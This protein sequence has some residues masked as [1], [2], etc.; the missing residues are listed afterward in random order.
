MAASY[1]A[2]VQHD[3]S[4]SGSGQAADQ[5]NGNQDRQSWYS[6][7]Q[8]QGAGNSWD[9]Y[10]SNGW[11][12]SAP[13]A[14]AWQSAPSW[15]NAQWG[16]S[17]WHGAAWT[18]DSTSQSKN[19]AAESQA[20]ASPEEA[21]TTRRQSA[22]TME[23][24]PWG[25][26]EGTGSLDDDQGSSSKQGSAAQPKAT[27]KDYIPEY[28]GTTPMREYQR[29]VKLFEMSTGIDPSFRAQKLM[30]K[31]SGNAWLA[32]ESIPLELEPL[33]FLRTFQTLAD[34][35]KGFRRSKGQ[36]FVA[37]DMEFR[38]HGQRLEE[39][40]AG[41][42]G[43]TKAY[44]FLEKASLS[45][46][47]RKQVV[48]AA[49]GQYDYNKLRAAVMAI[50][51]QVNKE[52]DGPSTS[53]SGGNHRQWRRSPAKVHATTQDGDENM[54]APEGEEVEEL[55][56]E[57]LEE[58]LQVLMTQ[59]AKK[60]AQVERARGYGAPPQKGANRGETPE[61]RERRI[62]ELKRR[63]PCS[64]CK[65]NGRTVYGHWHSDAS[66]PFNQKGKAEA[67]AGNVMAVIE[68]ELSDS[69]EYGPDSS[70]VFFTEYLCASAVSQIEVDG[71]DH[72]LAL[73]DTCCAR[74]VAGE[75]WA[76]RHMRHL[77]G[78]GVDV[79]VVDEQ[80]P[81]RF[82]AGP[83]V[84]SRYGI[85][86]PLI[87]EAAQV[88]P[89]VR[90]SV[91]QQDV[92][93]LLSKTA[94]KGLGARLD[95]GDSRILLGKLGTQA[96]LIETASGLCGFMINDNVAFS[97]NDMT[98]PPQAMLEGETEIY[99]PGE[100]EDENVEPIYKVHAE[101]DR[102]STCQKC[103]TCARALIESR[104]FSYNALEMLANLLPEVKMKKQ[105]AINQAGES[106]AQG[107]VAGVWAHGGFSG[108]TRATRDLPWTI[109]YINQFLRQQVKMEWSSFVLMKNIKT[110]LHRDKNNAKQALSATV[111]FGN[112]QGG[113]LWMREG[114]AENQPGAS[115]DRR[116]REGKLVKGT[117]VSTREKPL[118]FD[119]RVSHGTQRW[120]GTRWCLTC[121]TS[122]AIVELGDNDRRLLHDLKFP[123]KAVDKTRTFGKV[124]F[125]RRVIQLDQQT[126]SHSVTV[127]AMVSKYTAPKK[128]EEYVACIMARTTVSAEELRKHDVER[129]K[130]IWTLIKPKKAAAPLPTGW[131]KYDV[132]ALKHLYETVVVPDLQRPL[133]N[134]WVR[135]QR[136][137]LVTEID[138]WAQ[139]VTEA[140]KDE[141]E[142]LYS[143]TPMC[144]SCQ[145]PFVIRTNR[146]TREDFFG[147]VRFP[148][149]R[150]T[151]ALT[152]NGMPA[153]TVQDGLEKERK[154]KTLEE[155]AEDVKREEKP[156]KFTGYPKGPTN[157]ARRKTPCLTEWRGDSSDGSWART[158]PL[159]VE[160]DSDHEDSSK[161]IN[162]NLTSEEMEMIKQLR[163]SKGEIEKIRDGC[164]RRRHLKKGAIK[165]FLGN[166]KA[167][168]ASVMIASTAALGMA[169]QSVPS[170]AVVRPDVLEVF[171]GEAQVSSSFGRW[172][173]STAK[174]VDLKLGD[175]KCDA[176]RHDGLLEW[177]ERNRPRLVVVSCAR[178]FK[179]LDVIDKSK[180]SQEKRRL[181]HHREKQ[182][183]FVHFV[184]SVFER[185][186]KRGDDVL[187]STCA[188]S[189]AFREPVFQKIMNHPQ[190]YATA[191]DSRGNSAKDASSRFSGSHTVLWLS[192]AL[193]I[194]EELNMLSREGSRGGGL[195]EMIHSHGRQCASAICK[196]YVK[197]LKRKDPSRV[198]KMLRQVA[199]RIRNPR[200]RQVIRDLRWNEKNISKALAR[201]SAVFAVDSSGGGDAHS[202]A[203]MHDPLEDETDQELLAADR[204]DQGGEPLRSDLAYDGVKFEVPSGRRLSPEIKEG[205]RKAH[206][207]LGHPSKA[208]L[209]RFLKLGG[210]KQEVV[211]AVDWMQCVSCAHSNRPKAHR[212]TNIPPCSI[213]FGDE[214]HLDCFCI[215][216]NT[217]EAYWFL[218]I[219]DR[220]TSY[221]VVELLR[222]HSPNELHRAFD[223]AWA[224]WAGPPLRVSVDFEGGFRGKEF[225]NQVSESGASLVSI[226]GTAHWQ[227][228][229]VERHNQT[230]KDM[231]RT[232]IRHTHVRGREQIRV[233]G[234]E[235]CWAKNT[236]VREH[237][238]S[239]VALVF[240]KEP[241]VFGE[242][243][244]Q[245]EPNMFH[246][247]V[248]D[249]DSEVARRMRYRYHAKLEYVKSQARQMLARTA[250]NRVRK[251]T[252]PRVGQ[253]VFFWRA[254][255]KKEPS[256]WVGPA[257]VVGL[258]G[259]S[260][261]VAIGGRCFLVAGEHLREACGDE[262]NFGDPQIQKAIALFKKTPKEAT[263]EDL[264]RQPPPSEE[265]LEIEQ[266]SFAHD[267]A[268]DAGDFEQGVTELPE[269]LRRVVKRVGW[270]QDSSGNPVLVT[271]RAWAYRTPEAKYEGTSYP[272][273]T[274]WGRFDGEWIWLEK[275]VKWS[276]LS[277]PNSFLPQAPAEILITAFSRRSKREM[278]LDDVPVVIK[279]RRE[280]EEREAAVHAVHHGKIV[281]KNKLKRMMDKEVPYEKIP[282]SER[283]AYH[284]AQEKEWQSWRQ[285]ESCEVL[286]EEESAR[287]LR[288]NPKRVLPS[289][290]VY[291]NKNAGLVDEQGR[292][293]P[294]RA[295]ARLCLQGHLCPDSQTGQVQVDSPTVERVSTML[296]LHMC[297]SYGWS[298]NWFIGDIS[299]AFLQGAPLQGKEAMYMRPPKQ[300]LKGVGPNQ[301]LKLLK[302]V[303]GRPDAP[304]AWYE[305]L[306]KVLTQELGFSK[307]YIDPAVFMLRN[308]EGLL[309]GVMIIHV[310]DLMV[311]HDG[312]QQAMDAI[313]RLRKRFPFG[314][315]E[316]V[317]DKPQGVTY[318]GK[319]IC[320]RKDTQPYITLAQDGFVDGRLEEMDIEP[321]RK[322]CPEQY[323]SEEERAEYRSIVG[324]LQWLSTQSRPDM[325]FETNQLQ[326]RIA[327]LR[328]FDLSR[329]NKAVREVK[330]NRMLLTFRDLGRDAQL[331]V[332]SDAGL[333]SSVGAE[334]SEQECE[335]ILQSQKDKKLVYS[336]KGALVGFVKRGSTEVRGESTHVNVLDWKSS[337]NRRVLESSF[338]GETHAALM[339]L[340]MGHFCQVL[341]SELRFGSDV[342]GSVDDDGWN[343]LVPMT[344][345]TD[346]R[347]IYDTVHKDGQHISDKASVV[348]AVL[349]R[350]ALTTRQ[351]ACR[352]R[353]L[354]VPTRH[355]LA[356]G[357]TKGL[358]AKETREQLRQGAVFREEAAKRRVPDQKDSVIGVNVC[359]G[360]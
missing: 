207:N 3:A 254:E 128:K 119:P 98:L 144:Q 62:A 319:E 76:L 274:T 147:C 113:E 72:R 343:D 63:M 94:L 23:E 5:S 178:D 86:M 43:V 48:A 142:D 307:S 175:G 238:W 33:E 358:R 69:D 190:V 263:F 120:K 154:A 224:K 332:Y 314:T 301:I 127:S 47:L 160:T 8:W 253:M 101:A 194:C 156:N 235:V 271:R 31:L 197:V 211:E 107:L 337:T 188:A 265:P 229:K 162:A 280:G 149:S 166:A 262:R 352:V 134:H 84:E 32:T 257:Y 176:E 87:V 354:W 157:A 357:L 313:E 82:G 18:D 283:A 61:A 66:C 336:Q 328:V 287:V 30:E 315:W 173:W 140:R 201:W 221:H 115:V 216:D 181:K 80:R 335:D 164:E 136:P 135:W 27:G 133:D 53:S 331:I 349:L 218:S 306:A 227:A 220:A 322:R 108:I 2:E 244:S 240:G 326:K 91:V 273:R 259:S 51:P 70:D 236:L 269:E 155:S 180:S 153:K 112:F 172:G 124:S 267:L 10:G 28:D 318:C 79:Y 213:T 165:R 329:A 46:E 29:R 219:V 248:G 239:P 122:R 183:P 258:Q 324:S 150:N 202:D 117:V 37:Y 320:L 251:I 125:H 243:H 204:V 206:C 234:R 182:L 325:S 228:G 200:N 25:V 6:S 109:K 67:P 64:A 179:S 131:K 85:V 15:G 256:R 344:L 222:D 198:R 34:F 292:A 35:Y 75:A 68:E 99:V 184:E 22:S 205:L 121:Y 169:M 110:N 168:A 266:Q 260:A 246:P 340:G 90:V 103:E 237:G 187:V 42:A 226:A 21:D 298:Q 347:S 189:G 230:V 45:S 255:R 44:W 74:S 203:P 295:K 270:T 20:Q 50:V 71:H 129:L 95:L 304:R 118:V 209:K 232:V 299:N 54:E 277:N 111:T 97:E 334:I 83:R 36:E 195:R 250:H 12:Y 245:G 310:D 231:L 4:Q 208:D 167:V 330:E 316:R 286:S 282:E 214:V 247:R 88:T 215:H 355:Q 223:R 13:S 16:G 102:G 348:H 284:E 212:T 146:M 276:E 350:Q 191:L 123:L 93:L 210:A 285:Y 77:H 161:V 185:Q 351:V 278:T 116:D 196:G 52:D 321:S 333:Y 11:S 114:S 56:V 353:L 137:L 217:P 96:P 100:A 1:S 177:V 139:E 38:R 339:G 78:L 288:E 294:V 40:G 268:R 300:G 171:D 305:E 143:E 19:G 302:P 296:F 145:I 132:P 81:F 151:M 163:K 279:R 17:W 7:S 281:G 291:R 41:I 73:S 60:R 356:D 293:L 252:N 311:C 242:L 360:S 312:S 359:E 338:A 65:A 308:P 159:P 297:I 225:W 55:P 342:V 138:M 106:R 275:D 193:E 59:A 186:M 104:D 327:D 341:M 170:T 130:Q 174:P 290:Y 14:W 148:M 317:A 309:I 346:C 39:V 152:Y 89:W 58:E 241:R 323:A 199:A 289:R 126:I 92:P 264:T 24:D 272:Y 233:A 57:A 303:Y 26:P 261:W 158:G 49:G 345:V 105:R 192:T 9:Y 141:P 249:P